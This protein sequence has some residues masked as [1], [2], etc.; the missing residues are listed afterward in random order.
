MGVFAAIDFFGSNVANPATRVSF[1]TSLFLLYFAAGGAALA[2][3]P[4]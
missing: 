1:L 4:S 2:K 3:L